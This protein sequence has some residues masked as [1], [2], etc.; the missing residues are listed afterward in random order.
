M[1][2]SFWSYFT[3]LKV[4]CCVSMLSLVI[5]NDCVT[6]FVDLELLLTKID[7]FLFLPGTSS[8]IVVLILFASL[9]CL[10]SHSSNFF[11]LALAL[12]LFYWLYCWVWFLSGSLEMMLDWNCPFHF[13][14]SAVVAVIA[15]VAVYCCYFIHSIG[16]SFVF[17]HGIAPYCSLIEPL[18]G[19]P[20]CCTCCFDS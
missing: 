12:D 6:I 3:I 9:R 17:N 7:W 18:R 2:V 15:V 13:F 8:I 20:L 14:S 19:P 1:V 10:L 11:L 4:C 16:A 5:L